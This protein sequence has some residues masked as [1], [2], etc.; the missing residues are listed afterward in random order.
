MLWK[1]LPT[2]PRPERTA[3]RGAA[4]AYDGGEYTAADLEVSRDKIKYE[5]EGGVFRLGKVSSYVIGNGSSARGREHGMGRD[6]GGK[7]DRRRWRFNSLPHQS[8][9]IAL[10]QVDQ[11]VAV[12]DSGTLK[13]NRSKS[14][15]RVTSFMFDS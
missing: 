4:R 3:L 7:T 15:F 10:V 5:R 2:L 1:D 6:T 12:S 11:A 8:S 14:A 9:R 13:I